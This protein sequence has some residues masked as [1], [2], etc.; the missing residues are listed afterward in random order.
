MR[1]N[2]TFSVLWV[3][4]GMAGIWVVLKEGLYDPLRWVVLLLAVF[5]VLTALVP[6]IPRAIQSF[7]ERSVPAVQWITCVLWI[8]QRITMV[9]YFFVERQMPYHVEDN[10]SGFI[11][12]VFGLILVVLAPIF[13]LYITKWKDN[14]SDS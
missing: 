10:F 6:M 13:T 5:L 7:P 9:A 8:K 12:A 2:M 4:A 11:F 3:S 1:N 14:P